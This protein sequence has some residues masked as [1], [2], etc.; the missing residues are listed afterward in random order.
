MPIL[1]FL[2]WLLLNGRVTVETVCFGLGISAALYALLVKSLGWKPAWDRRMLRSA[3]ILALYFLNLVWETAKAAR[4]VAALSLTPG[5][6]P[7][8]VLVEF[9]S[10]LE[11]E[12]LN[13]LL[14]NS[15]TLTPGT[16]TV[17]QDKDRF[18]VHALRKEYAEGLEDSSFVRLLRRF[19]Q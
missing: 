7:E 18:L 15:I 19:P 9:R 17:F 4:T 3:P 6:H 11:G 14:A 5:E 10:G 13:V 8:P 2:L 12:A 16:I 1:I